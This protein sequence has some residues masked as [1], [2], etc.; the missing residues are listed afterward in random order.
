MSILI[1]DSELNFN[2]EFGI[3]NLELIVSTPVCAASLQNP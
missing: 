3:R 1:P 2:L